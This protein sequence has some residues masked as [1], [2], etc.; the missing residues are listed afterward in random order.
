MALE[1]RSLGLRGMGTLC[2][3]SANIEP[4]SLFL[5][6]SMKEVALRLRH[7]ISPMLTLQSRPSCTPSQPGNVS[8]SLETYRNRPRQTPFEFLPIPDEFLN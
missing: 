5:S 8:L 6:V 3:P 1:M 7:P 2:K 4:R